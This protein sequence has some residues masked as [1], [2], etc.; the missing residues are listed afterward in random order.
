[1]CGFLSYQP[2]LNVFD[3]LLLLGGFVHDDFWSDVESH[4]STTVH[5]E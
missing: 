1:V 2:L 4:P 3:S 5:G